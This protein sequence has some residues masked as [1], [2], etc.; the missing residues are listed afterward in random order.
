MKRQAMDWE[1][2][3]AKHIICY[4]GLV[5]KT[6]KLILKLNNKKQTTHLQN[7]PRI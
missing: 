5:F 4:K 7:K 1:K 6:Y 3:L 2:M